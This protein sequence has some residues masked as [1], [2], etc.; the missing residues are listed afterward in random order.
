MQK[1][2]KKH[3]T[4]IEFKMNK[5]KYFLLFLLMLVISCRQS[6]MESY[7]SLVKKELNSNKKVND[8][9]FGISLGMTA[10][11]FYAHCWEMNKKGMFTDGAN[12][13]AVLYEL[14]NKE[15]QHPAQMNFYPEFHDGKI[16]TL[17]ARFQY[18]GWM[19][20]NKKLGSDSLLND[21]VKLY[22]K[23]YKGGNSFIT[24]SDEKKGNIYVKVDGNRRI[25]I[26]HYDDVEVKADY[27]DLL[28]EQQMKK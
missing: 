17:W 22:K 6:G 2:N 21:V 16:H 27:T 13:T 28:V 5:P 7:R 14:D 26:G 12:N 18:K 8:I 19:P 15:L 20:W 3:A 1:R 11:E 4:A 24:I 10:K 23:W 9:F 25:M